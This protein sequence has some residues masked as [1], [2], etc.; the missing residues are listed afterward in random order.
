MRS[1]RHNEPRMPSDLRPDDK[2]EYG[3]RKPRPQVRPDPADQAVAVE[4][5]KTIASPIRALAMRAS[6]MAMRVSVPSP[7]CSPQLT[8]LSE[9]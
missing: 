7:T 2:R 4:L 8:P 5:L 3:R 6:A 1:V 9:P